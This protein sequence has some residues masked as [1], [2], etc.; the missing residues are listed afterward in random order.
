MQY[1][2]Q[3]NVWKSCYKSSTSKYKE[4]NININIS[5]ILH[6]PSDLLCVFTWKNYDTVPN[7]PTI[8]KLIETTSGLEPP[9]RC[10]NIIIKEK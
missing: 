4:S 8:N 3:I 2:K 5:K 9:E 7:V 1:N 6:L 10:D